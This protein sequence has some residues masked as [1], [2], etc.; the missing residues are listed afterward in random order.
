MKIFK[1]CWNILKYLV[2]I[3]WNILKYLA[4]IIGLVIKYIMIGLIQ[5]YRHCIGPF[6]PPVCRF[7]PS[8]STYF[9]EALEKKGLIKGTCL[10]IYRL[11]R[12]HPFCEGGYDPVDKDESSQDK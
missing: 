4:S 8:C 6:M 10:G 3:I 12:C 9:L 1:L 7:Q 11:L 2:T 5:F